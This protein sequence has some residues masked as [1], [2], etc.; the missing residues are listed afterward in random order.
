MANGK[1][2]TR[3]NFLFWK[4][5]HCWRCGVLLSHPDDYKVK[6]PNGVY[7]LKKPKPHMAT[8][9]HLDSKYSSERGEH[10]GKFRT[11]LACMECCALMARM[12]QANIP[13][14]K[15]HKLA[16]GEGLRARD[17][18]IMEKS[19]KQIQQAADNLAKWKQ[20]IIYRREIKGHKYCVEPATMLGQEQWMCY[21]D[22]TL[23]EVAQYPDA[24]MEICQD[25]AFS[26]DRES[27]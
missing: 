23:I 15:L 21:C 19:D 20:D 2:R 27:A 10:S 8:L 9:Y 17:L 16:S 25:H 26:K 1:Q 18:V 13:I 5:P 7:R 24:A 6:A 11:I 4:D 12:T 3:R 14:E 22:G